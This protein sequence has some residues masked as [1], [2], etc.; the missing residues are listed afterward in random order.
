VLDIILNNP[1]ACHEPNSI[2][3][4][5]TNAQDF[6]CAAR[7]QMHSGAMHLIHVAVLC[8]QRPMS[9]LFMKENILKMTHKCISQSNMHIFFDL[10]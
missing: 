10:Y 1:F 5:V 6:E 4:T 9:L 7:L 3:G 2:S 8:H